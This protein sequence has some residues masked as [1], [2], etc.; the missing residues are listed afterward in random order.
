MKPATLILV[1]L[2]SS[3]SMHLAR[4]QGCSDA[5]VCTTGLLTT[6]MNDA[7]PGPEASIGFH[8]AQGDDGTNIRSLV[9]EAFYHFSTKTH[10]QVRAPY[11]II[12]GNPL[13]MVYQPS[14]GTTD[15]LIGARW[16]YRGWNA[17]LGYQQPIAQD[18]DNGF[19]QSLWDEESAGSYHDS[20]QLERQSDLVARIEKRFVYGGFG[21]TGGL[22][23]I[24]HLGQDSYVN[25][26][27]ER[28]DIEGSER[29]T[30]NLAVSA[31]YNLN[32]LVYFTAFFGSPLVTRD[33]QP[34][35]LARKYAAGISAG[36]RF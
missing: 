24:Y 10:I 27:E 18:N 30:L 26:N 15:I 35:G 2:F 17:S 23:P 11:H 25:K 5:G 9:L 13:P 20:R 21:I 1:F 31:D 6:T 33:V 22:V 36:F 34:A 12:S 3:V 14:L 29:L 7:T 8:F 32:E 19:L 4:A 28:V 16:N